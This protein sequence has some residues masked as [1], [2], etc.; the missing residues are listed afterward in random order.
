MIQ[1]MIAF[2]VAA[3]F[4]W[5]VATSS[6]LTTKAVTTE[7]VCEA[8]QDDGTFSL[9]WT[10]VN[11]LPPL[12]EREVIDNS[13]LLVSHETSPRRAAAGDPVRPPLRA[14]RASLR[15]N[16][17]ARHNMR[18]VHYGRTWRCRR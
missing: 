3:L 2:V 9:R 8:R 16:V 11:D 14:R 1:W 15:T 4:A 18:V 6:T 10:P 7:G 5:S 17:C 12:R 13:V